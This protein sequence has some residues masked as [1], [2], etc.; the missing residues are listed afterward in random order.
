MIFKQKKKINKND[1]FDELL[2]IIKKD[3]AAQLENK[4]VIVSGM[5]LRVDDTSNLLLSMY[6]NS[7]KRP[8]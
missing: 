8:A 7:T 6:I 5:N 3:I 1:G 4:G 2:E